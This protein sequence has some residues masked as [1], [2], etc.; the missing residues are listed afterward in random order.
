[1]V[2]VVDWMPTL[3]WYAKAPI[4]TRLDGVNQQIH[5]HKT[6]SSIKRK[7]RTKF[8]YGVLHSGRS[9]ITTRYVVRFEKWKYF[10]YGRKMDTT[11]CDMTD[12]DILR[13]TQQQRVLTILLLLIV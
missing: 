6:A 8:I 4:P 7:R 13:Q 2:H 3:L 9:K 11:L 5:F 12:G 1:M 10:N